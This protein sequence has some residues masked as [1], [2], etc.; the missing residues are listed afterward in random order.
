MCEWGYTGHGGPAHWHES[1]PQAGGK[2]QSPIDINTTDARFDTA[3]VDR[4]LK[5][6]YDPS[7]TKALVNN[8]HTFRVDI[9]ACDYNLSGGPL[10]DNYQLVQFHAHWGKEDKEGAE[11]TINGKQYAAEIHLVH[12]NTGQFKAVSDAIKCDKGIAVLGSFIKVG[13]PHVGFEKLVP[14]LKKALNKNCTA[15][16]E[17]GFDPS[18]LLPENKKD[19]WTYEGSL[20]TPPCY[21]SVSFILFK[22][23]IE[24]SEEQL[25]VLRNLQDHCDGESFE[26]RGKLVNNY[27]PLCDLNG[28]V[29]RATFEN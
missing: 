25:Q 15:P 2:R 22:D 13:K 8:G 3:L 12:W 1:F 4:P 21:E 6:S 5:I 10:E 17:G 19:Y 7:R 29:V 24:V 14:C 27:R 16:V 26:G 20:T 18:C 9:D 28:R 11:H 23:A